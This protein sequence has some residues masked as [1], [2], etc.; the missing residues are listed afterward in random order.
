MTAAVD[1]DNVV[2]LEYADKV[3]FVVGTA[4]ISKQSVEEV[5]TLLLPTD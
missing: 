5:R 1:S 3:I 2:R 4:H